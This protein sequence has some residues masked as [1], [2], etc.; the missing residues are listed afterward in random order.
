MFYKD[1]FTHPTVNLQEKVIFFSKFEF[2][3]VSALKLIEI[4]S[5]DTSIFN[6]RFCVKS[7]RSISLLRMACT[8]NCLPYIKMKEWRYIKCIKFYGRLNLNGQYKSV[9]RGYRPWD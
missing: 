7:S 4:W 3:S 9:G 1:F 5:H 2:C 8:R 6:F